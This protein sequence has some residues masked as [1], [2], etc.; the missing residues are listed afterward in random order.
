MIQ[1][2]KFVVDPTWRIILKDIG[3]SENEV[4]QRA[5]LP[6][7]LFSKKNAALDTDEYFRMWLGLEQTVD[8]PF[9]A[10][11]LGRIMTAESF[12]PPL[13]AALCSPDLNTAMERLSRFK[14]L[15]GPMTLKV[16]K[17]IHSTKITLDCL[18]TQ[19]PLPDSLA[20][21]EVIFLVHLARLGT[22]ETIK[23]ISVT[24]SSDILIQ[25]ECEKYIGTGVQKGNRHIVEFS[26][27]DGIRPFITENEGMW[28][29]FEPELRKRLADIETRSSFA[30]RVRASLFEMLPSGAATSDAVASHLAV[31]KR[32]LQRHLKN[33]NTSF[34]QE[35]NTTRE[36][37]ARHYLAHSDLP[38]SQI[39]FLLGYDD[40]NS[41]VRAFRSWTGQTPER[42][43][44]G[45]VRA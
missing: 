9:F 14:Q 37:L 15:I 29:F 6:L 22:R 30:D 44:A 5:K 45:M 42:A 8:D 27:A 35:L 3:V 19:N 17:T 40:P 4:L 12:S 16:K 21:M 2:T 11:E 34:Q 20:A 10:L 31:S 23:P 39:S 25:K 41:F 13:F 43:R 7:D 1:A 18:Y 33:E 24:S 32:T 36:K 28:R 26:G 38:G